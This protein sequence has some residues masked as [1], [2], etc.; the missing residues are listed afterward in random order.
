M[1]YVHTNT[2]HGSTWSTGLARRVVFTH[3]LTPVSSPIKAVTVT[4]GLA[5]QGEAPALGRTNPLFHAAADEA[6]A[7]DALVKPKVRDRLVLNT[8]GV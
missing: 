2:T 4:A 8:C 1:L 5:A 6:H 7:A 3:A